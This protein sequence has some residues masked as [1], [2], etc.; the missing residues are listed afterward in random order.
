LNVFEDKIFIFNG[1][2]YT[3]N[4]IETM[5][6]IGLFLSKLSDT[7]R[8]IIWYHIIENKSHKEIAR[9]LNKEKHTKL[10]GEI[11]VQKIHW[12]SMHRVGRDLRKA[13]M[14]YEEG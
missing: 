2:R 3:L 5:A 4:K 8:F 1:R 10:Y 11:K 13:D 6:S 12:K 14:R 7:A 9:M